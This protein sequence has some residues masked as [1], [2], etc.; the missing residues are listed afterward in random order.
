MVVQLWSSYLSNGYFSLVLEMKKQKL[1]IYACVFLPE[2][3]VSGVSSECLEWFTARN[4]GKRN[5]KWNP[6][7]IHLQMPL[8]QHVCIQGVQD[9]QCGDDCRIL[10]W[11]WSYN[12]IWIILAFV[13]KDYL[14]NVTYRTIRNGLGS[15]HND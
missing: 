6:V 12:S 1:F 15:G 9:L 14:R 11:L 13:K 2:W 3:K 8:L 4:S 5:R 10:I 7:T